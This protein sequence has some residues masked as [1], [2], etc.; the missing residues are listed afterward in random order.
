M[1]LP[2]IAFEIALWLALASVAGAV[3]FLGVTLIREWRSKKLW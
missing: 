1:T 2:S 3:V